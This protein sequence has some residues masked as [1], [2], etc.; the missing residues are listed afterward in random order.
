MEDWFDVLATDCRLSGDADQQVRELGFAVMPGAVP[1]DELEPLA[2]VYD[3]AVASAAPGD[4]SI[5]RSTTR[6]HDFVNRG[7]AFDSLYVFPPL[8]EACCHVIGEAFK[9]STIHART[10]RAYSPAQNLHVDFER[11]AAGFPMVGFIFML[12]DFRPDNGTTRFVPGSHTWSTVPHDLLN[13]RVADY[14]GQFL[15]CGSAGSIIIFN[16]SVWHGHTANSS[17]KPRRSIQG[18][19]IRR[20]AQSW[21]NLPGRAT[22]ETLARI[23]PIAR[24]LIAV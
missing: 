6:V 10:L 11:D 19:Y 3:V 17:G 20:N 15:A 21:V 23:S 13:D 5:G 22:P 4:V 1:P 7:P 18:A 12:D 9:L 2:E 24:Y 16:G 14:E 8:L